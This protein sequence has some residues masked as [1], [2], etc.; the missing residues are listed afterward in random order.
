MRSA[1]GRSPLSGG[2]RLLVLCLGLS[3]LVAVP[4]QW[5]AASG[6]VDVGSLPSRSD[7][8]SDRGRLTPGSGSRVL[9]RAGSAVHR[10]GSQATIHVQSARL[11]DA[12]RTEGPVNPP[13]E[14]WIPALGIRAL[15]KPVGVVLPQ[16]TMQIPQ[17]VRMAGWYRFGPS[18][19]EPGSAILVG[20]V[21]SRAQGRGAFFRLAHI[22]IGAS[23]SV[24][25]DDGTR[26]A[27]KVVARRSYPKDH[28]PRRIFDRTGPP[29]LTLVTCGGSF[30]ERTRSY[31][32]NIVIF[33]VIS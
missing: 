28:L 23:I 30:D 24:E 14:V 10:S 5:H 31:S 2:I 16:G 11:R 3:L 29:M 17:D 26:L 27:F 21:D 7:P 13:V 18:P 12:E 4:V 1:L 9:A 20:H 25:R 19:G 8:T 22:G 33:A 32:D 6:A 15:I